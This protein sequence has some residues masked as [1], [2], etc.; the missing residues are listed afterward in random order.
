[1]QGRKYLLA[2]LLIQSLA[3]FAASLPTDTRRPVKIPGRL[4]GSNTRRK[5]VLRVAPSDRADGPA[6]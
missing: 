3:V 5:M 4:A 6:A 2:P 1:L